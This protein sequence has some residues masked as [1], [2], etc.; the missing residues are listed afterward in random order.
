A[1][2]AANTLLHPDKSGFEP[3]AGFAWRPSATG[4]AIVRASYGVYRDTAVYRAIADQMAQQSP[5]SK[6]LSV[7]NTLSN[8]L[9]LTD[10]FHG[11]PS[12]TAATFAID[13]RFRAGNAQNWQ[14]SVQQDLPSAMQMTV[15]YLGIKGTHVPQRVLP[16]TF[17]A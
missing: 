14:L 1:G 15:T 7:Q 5:L 11:S 3:R 10:G 2:T 4:S 9:S 6:S 17:P 12:V 16:N 8:P 13:P